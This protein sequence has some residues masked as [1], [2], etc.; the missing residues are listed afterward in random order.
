MPRLLY[1]P[2]GVCPHGVRPLNGPSVIGSGNT[3]SLAGYHQTFNVPYGAWEFQLTYGVL[4]GKDARRFRGWITAMHGGG[5]AT[6]FPFCD[7][8]RISFADAD[9]VLTAPHQYR[10]GA[11]WGNGQP[12]GNAQNWR[13]ARSPVLADG[14]FAK[15]TSIIRLG[16]DRWGHALE[17]GDYIGFFPSH[18]GMYVIT[19][20]FDDKSYRIWPTLRKEVTVTDYCTL[21]PVLALRLKEAKG[22]DMA[23]DDFAIQ[24]PTL[25]MIEVLHENAIGYFNA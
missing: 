18:F 25:S 14:T 11:P 19:E 3:Q 1:P 20:V 16:A 7:L 10:E 4:R 23:R 5:N 15:G 6:R 17:I 8:D 13:I 22:V 9:V 12:W 24:N 21:D 2:T